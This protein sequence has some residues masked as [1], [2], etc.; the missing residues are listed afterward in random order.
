MH[1]LLLLVRSYAK[2]VKDARVPA[3]PLLENHDILDLHL[4]HLYLE[5]LEDLRSL[6][7]LDILD[8]H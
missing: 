3:T 1:K 6:E 7:I 5:S 2:A 8:S 4:L